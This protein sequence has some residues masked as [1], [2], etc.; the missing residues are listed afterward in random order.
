M[1]S[2]LGESGVIA[3]TK[4]ALVS[5]LAS[6]AV[7]A[8]AP[9]PAQTVPAAAGPTVITADGPVTGKSTPGVEAFLGIP[10]AEPP[11]GSLRWAAPVPARHHDTALQAT[12][13]GPGCI[14]PAGMGESRTD[15]NCLF[16][17]VWRPAG[18]AAGKKLPVLIYIHGGAFILGSGRMTDGNLARRGVI[19]VSL[20]YRLGVLGYLANLAIQS[21]NK[22]KSLGNFALMDQM[23]ALRWVKNNIA[24]FG[25]DPSNVTAWGTSGGAT[26]LFSLLSM[27]MAK[28]LFQRAVL[29]SGG[30]GELSNQTRDQSLQIGDK[31]VAALGCDKAS[32]VVACLRAIPAAKTMAVIASHWRPTVDGYVLP[33]VPA[34]TF[35]SGQFNRVPV[36]I[37]GVF[38]EG[39]LF[40]DRNLTAD[41]YPKALHALAP[42]QDA[43]KLDA[44]YP[45]SS[46]AVPGQ[47]MARALGDATYGCGNGYRREQLSAWVPVYGWEMTD[48][49]L[50]FPKN[51]QKF[52]YGTAHGMDSYYLGGSIAQ[53]KAY[54]FFDATASTGGDDNTARQ[55]LADQ[56][57]TYLV[58][59]VK[60]GNPNGA[61]RNVTVQWPRYQGGKNRFIL[62]LSYPKIAASNG[63]FE[64][65]HKCGT[66]W[67]DTPGFN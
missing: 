22:D 65:F 30:A 12:D 26:Q 64:A 41:A 66:V 39:T 1:R 4:P 32:D 18:V 3:N 35:A 31:A 29:Q 53:L 36:M 24:A 52:Y 51:P 13:F 7:A 5:L 59:F 21:S 19:V 44:A 23:L 34:R 55:A 16:V 6:L 61:A 33:H 60:T 48:P 38:D 8:A 37:G 67:H 28:G 46:F 54:P 62:D 42:A 45:L 15:E 63:R 10:Y 47:A 2:I 11:V 57:A 56:V 17:N 27:P 20:N 49:A 50:S 58:N 9:V 25:G 40:V 14:Q 43:A